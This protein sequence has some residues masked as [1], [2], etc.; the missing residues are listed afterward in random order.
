M[1]NHQPA[2]K[3][4]A[5]YQRAIYAEEQKKAWMAWGNLIDHQI[6][7]KSNNIVMIKNT[8]KVS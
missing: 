3:L 2:N 5:T 1:L 4:I 7:N 6:A 8:M